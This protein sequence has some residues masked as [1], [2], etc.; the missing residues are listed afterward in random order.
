[1]KIDSRARALGS[2]WKRNDTGLELKIDSRWRAV[3]SKWKRKEM[4]LGH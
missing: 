2:K 3:G 4:L 1:M